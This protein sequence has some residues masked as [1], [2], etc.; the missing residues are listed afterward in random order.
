M[1]GA[2]TEAMTMFLLRKHHDMT[3][4]FVVCG[5]DFLVPGKAIIA[6]MGEQNWDPQNGAKSGRTSVAS[7]VQ[8]NKLCWS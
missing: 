6:V 7:T 8:V 2:V 4:T 3:Q 5:C 1:Q